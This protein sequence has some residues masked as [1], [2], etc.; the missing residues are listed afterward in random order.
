MYTQVSL[1]LL[2]DI[3]IRSVFRS[4]TTANSTPGIFLG[5]HRPKETLQMMSTKISQQVGLQ[6]LLSLTLDYWRKNDIAKVKLKLKKTNKKQHIV[7]FQ[8][9]CPSQIGPELKLTASL[10]TLLMEQD[11][12]NIEHGSGLKAQRGLTSLQKKCTVWLLSFR[13]R[14]LRKEIQYAM[15]SSSEKSNL[16]TIIELTWLLDKR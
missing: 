10:I 16:C 15:I 14:V 13:D 12:K 1:Q 6:L 9:V 2:S 8:S 11:Q 7:F 4:N 5:S 3:H